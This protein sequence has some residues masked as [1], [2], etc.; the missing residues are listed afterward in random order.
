VID[1]GDEDNAKHIY[2]MLSFIH[3]TTYTKIHQRSAVGRNLDFHIDL[4]L[5]GEQFDIRTL[6]Y[7]AATTFFK[8]ALFFTHTPWFPFALQR[9]LGPDAP[10]MADQFLV[11]I[12]I[13]ICTEQME[14]LHKN[15]HFVEMIQAG[16]LADDEM[17][18]KLYLDLGQR[19]RDMAGHA[20]WRSNEDRLA[21][22]QRTMLNAEAAMG[23]G[24]WDRSTLGGQIMAA[25]AQNAAWAALT[26]L[27]LL[28]PQPTWAPPPAILA[29]QPPPTAATATGAAGVAGAAG[30]T[31]V[32]AANPPP[33]V[34]HPVART[35]TSLVKTFVHLCPFLDNIC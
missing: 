32:L 27:A 28:V 13:K 9:V 23:E 21:E 3:G 1:L 35:K 22:A 17:M 6:R 12:C 11:E 2:A 15:E 33:P 19:V 26:N 4:Y 18:G 29:S 25:R 7:S 30:A 31:A 10:V 8:E 14:I 34:S 24:P 16:E 5:I 20:A